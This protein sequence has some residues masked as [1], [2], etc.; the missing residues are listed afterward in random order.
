MPLGLF[1]ARLK[2]VPCYKAIYPQAMK[3]SSILLDNFICWL[4][5]RVS[6]TRGREIN[7][8]M[9]TLL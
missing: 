6:G 9:T 3:S 8:F 4:L 1:S 7:A 2:V 5:H